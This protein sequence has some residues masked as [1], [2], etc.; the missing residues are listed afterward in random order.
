MS[1][2]QQFLA[3]YSDFFE[4]DARHNLWIRSASGEGL[5][6]YDRHN[7]IYA[8]GPLERFVATLTSAGLAESKD[9]RLHFRSQHAH[10]YHADF[11]SYED[12]ILHQEEWS[13]TPLQ[14]GDENPD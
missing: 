7:V 6:V 8:Y 4:N 9:T 5:L 12:R 11:D 13:L 10:H 14:P 1:Q 2:L 3:V